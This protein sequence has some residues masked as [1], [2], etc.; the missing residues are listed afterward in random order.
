[1]G[2][3]HRAT[4]ATLAIVMTL[5]SPVALGRESPSIVRIGDAV[6]GVS[7][8]GSTVAGFSVVDQD[9]QMFRW[10]PAGGVSLLGSGAAFDI[11]RD[12]SVVV[13][14]R[15]N[16]SVSRAVQWSSGTS[17]TE[18]GQLPNSGPAGTMASEAYDVSADGSVIVGY[19]DPSVQPGLPLRGFRWTAATG[20]TMLGDLPGGNN[21]SE[22]SAISADGQITVGF[23][24]GVA[25]SRAVRWAGSNPA[26]IDMGMPLGRTGFTEAKHVSADGL[27]VVGV[28]GNGVENE[29]FRWTEGGGYLMLGDL[30]GGILDSFASATNADG[31]VIVGMGNPGDEVPDEPFYWTLSGGMRSFRDVLLENGIDFSEWAQFTEVRDLSDDGNII[32]GN[33][34]LLD[35]SPAGFR[36]VIP[37]PTCG[38]VFITGFVCLRLPRRRS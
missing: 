7:A 8:D 3:K 30:P 32:V 25:G 12:G 36:V 27:V 17:V 22:A 10:T 9:V 6:T 19:A 5:G 1:M 37:S 21:R 33:G 14:S 15:F 31:S 23:S 38:S 2:F 35:G 18:L 26:P 4:R 29:A 11:S 28:W 34:I 24:D 16:G 20:M 13:G